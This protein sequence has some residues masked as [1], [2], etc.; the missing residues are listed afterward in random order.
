MNMFLLLFCYTDRFRLIA[1]NPFVKIA[2]YFYLEIFS[3]SLTTSEIKPL[4]AVP[5]FPPPT[6]PPKT[7][8]T[9]AEPS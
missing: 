1:L 2:D 9:F 5:T 6:K 4:L 7:L 8:S 3:I